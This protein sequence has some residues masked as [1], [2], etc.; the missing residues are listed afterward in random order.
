L[1]DVVS[2]TASRRVNGDAD[3]TRE[4]IDLLLLQC[5]MDAGDIGQSINSLVGL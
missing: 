1:L 4:L 2:C 3:G 5:S